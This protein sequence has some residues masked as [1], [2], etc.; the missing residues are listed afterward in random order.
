MFMVDGLSMFNVVE[1]C[2]VIDV[3]RDHNE[4]SNATPTD[5]DPILKRQPAAQRLMQESVIHDI[6][7]NGYDIMTDLQYL[8]SFKIARLPLWNDGQT[9]AARRRP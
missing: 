3:F 1:G 6:V 4:K 2:V 7:F 5:E 8:L 9:L